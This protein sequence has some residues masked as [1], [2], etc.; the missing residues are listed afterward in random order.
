MVRT[1]YPLVAQPSKGKFI[2]EIGTAR[3]L[4][5]LNIFFYGRGIKRGRINPF[6]LSLEKDSPCYRK[7]YVT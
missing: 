6:F 2:R 3:R 5:A 4:L 1:S 7:W